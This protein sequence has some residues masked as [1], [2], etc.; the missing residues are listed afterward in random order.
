MSGTGHSETFEP[1]DASN[2]SIFFVGY[3]KEVVVG[4]EE[5]DVVARDHYVVEY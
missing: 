1:A 4:P 3:D 5:T 2:S